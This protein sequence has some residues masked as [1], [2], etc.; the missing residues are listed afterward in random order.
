SSLFT[1]PGLR[2][3]S[4]CV[5]TRSGEGSPQARACGKF[6]HG[7]PLPA[8]GKGRPAARVTILLHHNALDRKSAL[9]RREGGRD[10][11]LLGGRAVASGNR[12]A[13]DVVL[14]QG[15]PY[16]D[17]SGITTNRAAGRDQV[18][19]PQD[20]VLDHVGQDK[21]VHVRIRDVVEVDLGRVVLERQRIL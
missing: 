6:P 16:G 4:D 10:V 9:V 21:A 5:L 13:G 11:R 3:G 20:V 2:E 15:I 12:R 19:N 17:R 7:D 18:G 14:T 1:S 8:N